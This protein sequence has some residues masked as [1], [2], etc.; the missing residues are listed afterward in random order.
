MGLNLLPDRAY[1]L[2]DFDA[3]RVVGAV[4]HVE[5]GRLHREVAELFLKLPEIHVGV[6]RGDV[7]DAPILDVFIERLLDDAVGLG[8]RDFGLQAQETVGAQ[9]AFALWRDVVMRAGVIGQRL[10]GPLGPGLE[11]ARR[12]FQPA[13]RAL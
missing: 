6:D 3:L 5:L 2:L 1:L 8:P 13:R 9:R 7:F 12:A 10:F 4:I 11:F